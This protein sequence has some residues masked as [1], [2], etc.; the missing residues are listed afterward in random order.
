MF[1]YADVILPIPLEKKFTYRLPEEGVAHLHIGTRVAVP[2]GK[3]KLYTGIVYSLHNQP[4]TAYEAKRIHEILDEEPIVTEQQLEHW[5]WMAQYYMCTLGEV[6]RAAL[7]GAFLL[8]SETLILKNKEIYLPEAGLTEIEFSIMEALRNRASLKVSEVAEIA[9]KKS[10]LPLL[11]TMLGKGY[12]VL[13]EQ[14]YEQYRPKTVRYLTLSPEYKSDKNLA[15]LLDSMTRAPKQQQ[16]ILT[17]F[18]LSGK[19]KQAVAFAKFL[20]ESGISRS[21]VT[22]LLEK[23]IFIDF[24]EQQ[25][26]VHYAVDSKEVHFELTHEQQEAL[27]IIHEN[28]KVKP[29]SLLHGVTSSGKTALY[30]YLIRE[31]IAR[32]EQVLYL[33]PEIALT[34][35]LIG[36]LQS[37]FGD[38]IAVYHSNYSVQERV[39]IWKHILGSSRK[40]QIIL[41]ARSALFT[42]LRKLGLV[43]V[44]EEHDGSYKQF[45]PA[46]RYHA[47]DAAI[48]LAGQ[49]GAKVLLG[50]ATPSVES[51]Y[52]V[53]MEKYGLAEMKTRY[54]DVK[55]PE[56]ALVDLKEAMRKR[57]MDGHF[58]PQLRD[59]IDTTLKRGSQVILFQNRRGFS[60]VISC[61]SCGHVPHCAN[62]DVS[63]TY[64]R[65]S[66]SLRCHYCG[67]HEP[68]PDVCVACGN[69]TLDTKGLG[70]EQVTHELA[71]LFPGAR[72][73]R[74]DYDT[75]RGKNAYFNIITAFENNEI[76]ILVGTQMVTKGLDFRNV[77]LVGIMNADSLLNFPDFKAHE[78]CFQLLT[79][80]AGRAGRTLTR[81]RVLVQTYNPEHP[82]L[83]FVKEGN[84]SA[85]Y[86]SQ[87]REREQFRYPPVNRIIRITFKH[88]NY[89]RVDHAANWF[90]G[91]L[92]QVLE[93]GI[94][95]PHSPAIGRIRNQ[96]IKQIL[97]KFPRAMS[98]GKIKNSIKR[99]DHSFNAIS[100]FRAV[101]IIYDV[102][103]L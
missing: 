46:P 80:V 14:L 3:S 57:R 25:D 4:P 50:S 99:I 28:W 2:F 8:E 70:T 83:Q 48:V 62:C 82:I 97:I 94:L 16:A 100:N 56:I 63:L 96:Y 68:L 45:D 54:G 66:Q 86:A 72:I 98:P 26:R 33:V 43:I 20:K 61:F 73:S 21:V 35:Q 37:Y 76:D 36:R 81:G 47:R 91:A 67:Y 5:E 22:A 18:Q 64:H 84:F 10:V 32:G 88:K 15:A 19:S 85:M 59:A 101:R 65:H 78:R 17:Y 30:V 12:I 1:S 95:G 90:A 41:G 34:A 42:P 60:P 51:Y 9:E 69:P 27:K 75:T 74:M 38:K 31:S 55:L 71:A 6:V 23:G 93:Q 58:T 79:Q 13:K 7:P 77:D 103:Y 44:D 102:D 40:A 39:E 24:M 53:A 49:L 92:K 89:Q 87:I 29:V 11:Q 52:N